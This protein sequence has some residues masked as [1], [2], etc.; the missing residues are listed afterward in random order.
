MSLVKDNSIRD[1]RVNVDRSAPV[2][3]GHGDGGTTHHIDA[4]G[5][6][7]L[8]QSGVQEAKQAFNLASFELDEA[9]AVTRSR[10]AA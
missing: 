1:E 5:H 8:L 6:S 3:N 10:S 2:K 7:A 4:A 9:H